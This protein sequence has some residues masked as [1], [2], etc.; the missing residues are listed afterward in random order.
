MPVFG[1]LGTQR[2]PTGTHG[3]H[4]NSTQ[5]GPRNK[6]FGCEANYATMLLK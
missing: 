3:E 2:E 5:E 4:E 6:A 1:S